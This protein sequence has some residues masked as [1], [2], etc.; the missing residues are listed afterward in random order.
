MLEKA[1]ASL[2]ALAS[3]PPELTDRHAVLKDV[4][5]LN[6]VELLAVLSITYHVIEFTAVNFLFSMCKIAKLIMT[7]V[8]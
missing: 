8:V 6:I 5:D 7:D 1:L 4:P 2:V 3:L